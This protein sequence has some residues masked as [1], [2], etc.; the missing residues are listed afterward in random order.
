ML[1]SIQNNCYNIALIINFSKSV[2]NIK[3]HHRSKVA[4]KQI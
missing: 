2:L 3:G 4:F 1:T